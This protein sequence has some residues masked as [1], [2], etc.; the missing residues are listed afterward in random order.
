MNNTNY[1]PLRQIINNSSSSL[2]TLTNSNHKEILLIQPY[3]IF[4]LSYNSKNHPL[5]KQSDLLSKI[6]FCPSVAY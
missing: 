5:N 1:K 2:L 6:L 4:I 3:N